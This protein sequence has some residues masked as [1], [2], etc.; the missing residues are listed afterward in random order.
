[1]TVLWYA[2]LDGCLAVLCA[3][4]ATWFLSRHPPALEPI[5]DSQPYQEPFPEPD[6]ASPEAAFSEEFIVFWHTFEHPL[7]PLSGVPTMPW[8]DSD[9]LAQTWLPPVAPEVLEHAK[10]DESP[11]DKIVP[12]QNNDDEDDSN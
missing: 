2:A 11:Y 5:D 10:D 3:A 7:H 6:D 1:M 4:T 8:K 12:R 9:D